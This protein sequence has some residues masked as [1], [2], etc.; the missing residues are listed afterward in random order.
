MEEGPLLAEV[1]VAEEVLPR[2]ELIVP[3]PL[4]GM[5]QQR[6]QVEIILLYL[7]VQEF[8][9]AKELMHVLHI[10]RKKVVQQFK[11]DLSVCIV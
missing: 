1:E 7:I 4:L 9:K 8:L 6:V 3:L 10:W 2:R 5:L 11:V